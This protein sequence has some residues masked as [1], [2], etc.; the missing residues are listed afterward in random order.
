MVQTATQVN[1]LLDEG[2]LP[3]DLQWGNSRSETLEK[4]RRYIDQDNH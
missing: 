4:W 2:A 1:P 3:P